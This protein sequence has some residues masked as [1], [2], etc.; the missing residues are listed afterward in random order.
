M[1]DERI[2]QKLRDG[3]V[4]HLLAQHIANLFIRD[5]LVILREKIH[6]NDDA[7]IDHFENIQSTN[8]RTMRLKPPPPNSNI[9]WRVEFRPCEIQLTDFENAAF[10]CFIALLTRVILAYK[11][12]FLIPISKV[13]ENMT[14]AQKRNAYRFERFWFRKDIF[15]KKQMIIDENG[16]EITEKD[17]ELMTIDE[18]FNGNGSSFPGLIPLMN[19]YLFSLDID[20]KTRQTMQRYLQLVE[21][22][23]SGALLTGA[24]W[25]RNE[26][27]NHPEYKYAIYIS[28]NARNLG[29]LFYTFFFLFYCGIAEKIPS[30]ANI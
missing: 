13:D 24:A 25:I 11:L 3:D 5:P 27:V 7:E 19:K 16:N 20:D 15:N 12:N 9:G 2:Y 30:L 14:R 8:W 29:N 10:A 26:I 28:N 23:A 18:I 4:D 6:Q 17:F 1:Y 22:K 21:R